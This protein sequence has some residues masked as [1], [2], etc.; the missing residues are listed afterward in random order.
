MVPFT[1]PANPFAHAIMPADANATQPETVGHTMS[2]D[3]AAATG[4][5]TVYV[6]PMHA[7]VRS[8]RQGDCRICGMALVPTRPSTPQRHDDEKA[9]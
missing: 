8:D 3:G 4:P 9:P 1:P 6:C 5:L 7:E 2:R